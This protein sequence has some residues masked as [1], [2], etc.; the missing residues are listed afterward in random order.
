MSVE[1]PIPT[2]PSATPWLTRSARARA[3]E[4]SGPF[5][6]VL[7]ADDDLAEEFDSRARFAAREVAT[8]RLLH[9]EIGERDLQPWLDAVGHGPGLL[10]LDGLMAIDTNGTNMS[11]SQIG[12]VHTWSLERA[13]MPKI[14][15][16]M[17]T[18]DA[19]R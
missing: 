7:D 16:G 4:S 5:A 1:G 3:P 2:S 19:M 18:R 14:T 13:V 8:A 17:I 15:R 6:Y 10:I 11:T 12:C 9:T